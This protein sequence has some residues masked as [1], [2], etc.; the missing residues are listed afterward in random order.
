MQKINQAYE[1]TIRGYVR[2][3]LIIDIGSHKQ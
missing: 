2:Y 1:R 3:R